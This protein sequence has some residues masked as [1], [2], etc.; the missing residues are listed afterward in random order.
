MKRK[1]MCLE[2]GEKKKK[3][4]LCPASLRAQGRLDNNDDL[5]AS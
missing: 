1:G 5:M 3:K 4:H 2:M